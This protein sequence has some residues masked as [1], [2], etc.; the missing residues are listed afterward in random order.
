[1]RSDLTPRSK[2]AA[3][4]QGAAPGALQNR[5]DRGE[6]RGQCLFSSGETSPPPSPPRPLSNS[7]APSQWEDRIAH[8]RA[9]R[10]IGH[11]VAKQA[12][13]RLSELL[14]RPPALRTIGLML[15]GPYANGKTMIAERFAVEHLRT[16]G[17]QRVWMVQTREGTGLVH[18]Y[19]KHSARIASAG[20][21]WPRCRP[22][23]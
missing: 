7:A 4:Q 3:D 10:R 20:R 16:A 1:M 12:H 14:S 19:G 9:P 5:V 21:Q 17:R 13:E 18:F 22:E 8:I 6:F 11:H 15:V 2:P 23:G